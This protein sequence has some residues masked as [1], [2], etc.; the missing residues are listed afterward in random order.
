[1]ISKI[2]KGK[3]KPIP[4]YVEDVFASSSVD[5]FFIHAVVEEKD[6]K[7]LVRAFDPELKK[8]VPTVIGLPM[9]D[10]ETAD[11]RFPSN[12]V[13]VGTCVEREEG[14]VMCVIMIMGEDA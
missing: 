7:K 6:Y 13:C 14:K 5:V 3:N 8:S 2:T 12:T 1:M 4:M 11:V 9:E 10:D